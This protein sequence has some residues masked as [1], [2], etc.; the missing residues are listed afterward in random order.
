MA[1]ELA[2]LDPPVGTPTRV[3][4]VED[5]ESERRQLTAALDVD[6]ELTLVAWVA[7]GAEAVR[8]IPRLSPD[9]V[10]VD[11]SESRFGSLESIR[12]IMSNRPVPIVVVSPRGTTGDDAL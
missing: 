7:D 1:V 8:A 2:A 5:S 11:V 12:H 6:S 10:V 3:M 9:I 4:V